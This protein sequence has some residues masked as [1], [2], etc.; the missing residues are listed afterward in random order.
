M[1][2]RDLFHG[3]T[4]VIYAQS[5]REFQSLAI[6]HETK[7][8]G[9]SL[10]MSA[11]YYQ[12]KEFWLN[13]GAGIHTGLFDVLL[14]GVLVLWLNQ[15]AESRLETRMAIKRNEEELDFWRND[16][17]IVASKRN[18]VSIQHLNE[19]GV[20]E[21]NLSDCVLYSQD[22]SKVILIGS[23]M[24]G[25]TAWD[26]SFVEADLRRVRLN[27]ADLRRTNFTGANLEGA[28]LRNAALMRADFQNANIK[29]A[30]FT[31][32]NVSDVIWKRA[33]YDRRTKFPSGF[34]KSDLVSDDESSSLP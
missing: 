15:R 3:Q 32:A 34:D 28:E 5:S 24:E 16:G 23:N 18:K 14:I 27:K 29:A 17:S 20:Y 1:T 13:I 12:E 4:G 11:Q 7:T 10:R 31:D 8:G 25:L 30:D 2:C 33:I 21:L 26:A 6:P 19:F 9:R 22:L